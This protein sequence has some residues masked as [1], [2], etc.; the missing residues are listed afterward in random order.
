[1][2]APRLT[3]PVGRQGP[4]AIPHGLLESLDL[5]VARRA[6]G[7]LPGDRRAAGLGSGTELAQLR[8]YE[9]GDDVR[10]IDAAATA[11]TGVPHVRLH[12]PERTLTT[13]IA[14]DLSP[15]MAFG[16]ADRLKSDVAEG[17]THVIGR[18]AIRRAG[19]VAL[20]TFGA[21][22]PRLIP[23]RASKPGFVALQRALEEGVAPDGH[24][25][26]GALNGA[27]RRIGRVATQPGLVVVISDWRDEDDWTRS[28]GALAQRHSVLAIEV[29]DPR[30]SSV[31]AVGRLA[32]V[33][34][35]TGERIEVDTSRRSVRDRFEQI[36]R[37]RREKVARELRR[38]QVQQIVLSTE[39]DWLQALGRRLS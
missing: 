25:E 28:L 34:P 14:L 9:V 2:P 12:V 26:P 10:Q 31:P 16:T 6:S 36:E 35:E 3:R 22:T 13:W 27:L 38:L 1:M 37:E 21:G 8:P 4:G 5:I 32:L 30:E 33:D 23:P 20:M 15:S 39:G 19:R 24:H 29:R 11:R 17:V 7:A 18:L